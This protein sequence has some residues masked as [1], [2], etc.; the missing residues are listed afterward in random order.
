MKGAF[1]LVATTLLAGCLAG[2]PK[3]VDVDIKNATGDSL[4]KIQ[5]KEEAEG[6]RL[7]GTLKGLPPGVHAMHIHEKGKCQ[8][9]DFTSAGNHFNPE[10]KEH[11]LLHPKGAHAGDLPNIIV[12]EN[13]T[14]KINIVAPNLTLLQGK[15][16]LYTTEGTSIVIHEGQDDGMSQPA[17]DA[18]GR[19]ACG[20][21]TFEQNK[22]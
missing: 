20:E 1:I 6:I 7:K 8:P 12:K 3:Q 14:V 15:N 19:I 11:G 2:D 21:I 22:K 4:G 16:T 5:L 10:K 18:G 17:G 13:E 9:P